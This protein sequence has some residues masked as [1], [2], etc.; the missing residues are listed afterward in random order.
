[1]KASGGLI[2]GL[3]LSPKILAAAHTEFSVLT[4]DPKVIKNGAGTFYNVL[5]DRMRVKLNANDTNGLFTLIEEEHD[6]GT[7]IPMHV[8]SNEDEVFRVVE[9]EVEFTIG[10]DTMVLG[11]GDTG[12]A[13]R[14]IPHTWKNVGKVQAKVIMSVFPAGLEKM[15]A[16]LSALPAGPP[17]F[18]KIATICGGYGVKF[19]T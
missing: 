9:G 4:T 16:E 17:D 2:A 11:A 14:N 19:L 3:S 7:Q 15:F 5:G 1:M 10:D 12:Y 13:P 8:H 6:P 18:A